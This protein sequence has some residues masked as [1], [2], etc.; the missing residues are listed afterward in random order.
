[1]KKEAKL[2]SIM[3]GVRLGMG[4]PLGIMGAAPGPSAYNPKR[5]TGPGGIS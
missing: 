2:G 4:T 1:V 5:V 3:E